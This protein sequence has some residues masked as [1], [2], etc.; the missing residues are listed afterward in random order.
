MGSEEVPFCGLYLESYKESQKGTTMEPMGRVQ[1][2]AFT[3]QG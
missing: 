3:L 1:P 2:S